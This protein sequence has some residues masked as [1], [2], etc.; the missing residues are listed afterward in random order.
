MK[1][2][3]NRLIF[4]RNINEKR[5]DGLSQ[6]TSFFLDQTGAIGKDLK[7]KD[8]P[9][10]FISYKRQEREKAR[11]IAQML[12][13][14]GYDVWWDVELLPGD[15]FAREIDEV[16]KSSK[17]AIVLWSKKAVES[18]FV[19]AEANRA[20]S[21]KILIPARLD[22][23]E[24][25]I[26]YN[27][28]HTLDLSAWEG[29]K[30]SPLLE[31]LV[32]AVK[33][34]IGQAAQAVRTEQDVK[35]K[36]ERPKRY[37]EIEYWKS[38]AESGSQNS[39]EYQAYLTKYGKDGVFYDLANVRIKSLQQQQGD[40]TESGL[41][42]TGKKSLISPKLISLAGI[43]VALLVAVVLYFL[44]GSSPKSDVTTNRCAS[45]T[46]IDAVRH[47]L[48]EA[49]KVDDISS[50][51]ACSAKLNTVNFHN[52]YGHS[53]LTAASFHGN[54]AI[55]KLLVKRGAKVNLANTEKGQRRTALHY[56]IKNGHKDVAKFLI[57]KNAAKNARDSEGKIPLDYDAS[58]YYQTIRCN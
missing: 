55:V 48:F 31:P 15:K 20:S 42:K 10:I 25:P 43:I 45:I 36:I 6:Y 18:D 22:D 35:K 2:I 56:A 40:E 37:G 49:I 50:V 38:I 39:A 58:G 53:P 51:K 44:P 41:E 4:I 16:I 1:I 3:K 27:T 19:R 26:P 57:C 5:E 21:K 9:D 8:M 34:K 52:Q 7:T 24:L 14:H 23:C 29:S 46:A 28:S 54:L 47:E 13:K 17:A 12:V 32:R 30:D 11:A 33:K